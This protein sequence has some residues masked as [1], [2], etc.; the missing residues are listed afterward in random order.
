MNKSNRKI[1]R[2]SPRRVQLTPPA[3]QTKSLVQ[4]FRESPFV[5]VELDLE[6][7]KI[8][9][10]K[11]SC[12]INLSKREYTAAKR[13]AKRLGISLAGLLRR[14]LRAL[15][16]ADESRSWMRYAGMIATG[17]PKASQRVDDVIYGQKDRGDLGSD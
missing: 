3:R 5:G 4:F 1:V 14:S 10:E 9:A 17:D 6:R 15:L 12:Q 7:N 8:P 13:E 16:F 11:C 2:A